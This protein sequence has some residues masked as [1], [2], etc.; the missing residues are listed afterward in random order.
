[1]HVHVRGSGP[2]R[3]HGLGLSIC[4]SLVELLGG[5]IDVDSRPGA[6]SRFVVIL[7]RPAVDVQVQACDANLFLFTRD[8]ELEQF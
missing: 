3:G 5:T 7:P 8:D 2:H 6:G 1:M 4:W